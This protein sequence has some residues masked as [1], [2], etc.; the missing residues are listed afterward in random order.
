MYQ[1]SAHSKCTGIGVG[2]AE[3]VRRGCICIQED[4]TNTGG[5][6]LGF[7]GTGARNDH[8]GAINLIYGLALLFIE[9]GI[10]VGELF[11]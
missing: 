2:K 7:A 6:Y 1:P 11:I 10:F 4:L 5:Q 8:H 9:T 3:D